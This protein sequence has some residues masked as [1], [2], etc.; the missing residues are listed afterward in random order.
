LKTAIINS[1]LK[2]KTEKGKR[3]GREEE[4]DFTQHLISLRSQNLPPFGPA[5]FLGFQPD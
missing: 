4:K 1:K 3:K 2:I 5:F